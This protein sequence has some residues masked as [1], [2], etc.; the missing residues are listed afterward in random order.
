MGLPA[1]IIR[2]K[3]RLGGGL[4]MTLQKNV[5]ETVCLVVW[6]CGVAASGADT[7]TFA[8][9]IAPIIYSNCTQCHR[10]GEIAPFP[11]ASYEDVRARGRRIA[12]VTGSRT[13]PPW[14]A[15][16]GYA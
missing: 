9:H 1:S 4:R 11:L 7:V 16:P 3:G 14:K 13:M 6:M 2:H 8:E 12:D 10:L 5:A 15:E